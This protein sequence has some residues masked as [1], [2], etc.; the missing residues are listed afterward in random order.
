VTQGLHG[1]EFPSCL[2]Q[3]VIVIHHHIFLVR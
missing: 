2:Y 1:E 3:S